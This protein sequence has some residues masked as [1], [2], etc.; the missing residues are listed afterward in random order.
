MTFFFKD[1][2]EMIVLSMVGEGDLKKKK[3]LHQ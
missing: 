1:C 2:D 3:K